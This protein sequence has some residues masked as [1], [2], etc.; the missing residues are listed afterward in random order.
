MH[1]PKLRRRLHRVKAPTLIIWGAEDG[2]VT[3]DYGRAYA[4]GIRGS[5]F[6][7]IDDA[8]HYPHIEQPDAVL[9]AL[10]SFLG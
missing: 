7:V 1:N 3:A 6:I 2:I 8:A 10:Y 9:A 5:Q 4:A